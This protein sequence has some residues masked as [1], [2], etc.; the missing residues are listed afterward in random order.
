MT[1]KVFRW[2]SGLSGV[3]DKV[4]AELHKF[5]VDMDF[6][7]VEIES[8]L[9]DGPRV[10][11]V[12]VG[13]DLSDSVEEMSQSPRDQVVMV[14]VDEDTL[15]Q[16]DS[17]VETGSVKSRSEAAALFIREG[18]KVRASELNKVKDALREVDDAR[19][20]LRKRMK[21]VFGESE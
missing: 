3:F 2:E 6:P 19:E 10:K 12:V 7:T 9:E 17:W 15:A 16:L 14:R 4:R 13:H 8:G 11:V 20:K 1:K 18:L 21:E 5:G